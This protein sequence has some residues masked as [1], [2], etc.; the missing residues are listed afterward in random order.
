[1]ARFVRRCLGD[2]PCAMVVHGR[3]MCMPLSHALPLYMHNF[4]S[5]DR[6][7]ARLAQFIRNK[8]GVIRCVDVGANIGDTVAALKSIDADGNKAG[9]GDLFLA[10]EPNSHFRRY[11]RQNWGKDETVVILPYICSSSTG[12]T[13]ALVEEINGTAQVRIREDASTCDGGFEKNT[14]D[15]IVQNH[16]RNGQFNLLKIDTD[17]HDFEVLK[18]AKEF[19]RTAQPFILFEVDS[20]SNQNFAEDAIDTL[21]FLAQCDYKSFILYDNFGYMMGVFTLDEL[22]DFKQLLFYK[23]TSQFHYF[24]ILV[25]PEQFVNEFKLDE[26][27][28]FILGMHDILMRKTAQYAAN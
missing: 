10:I 20:F 18:G 14:I 9:E 15:N 4:P 1:M 2:A 26:T 27:N 11:L 13:D 24:D 5:Y 22:V 25:M 7:P 16:I 21:R 8:L 12:K 28:Y 6:L 3:E 23:L 19:I 17:G